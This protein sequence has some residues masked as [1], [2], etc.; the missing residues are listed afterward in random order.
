MKSQINAKDANLHPQD[1]R[2]WRFNR[3]RFQIFQARMSGGGFA[4]SLQRF[5]PPPAR[6]AIYVPAMQQSLGESV[7]VHA[8]N[9][10]VLSEVSHF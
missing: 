7:L 10:S 1:P 4:P 2:K 3:L 8:D 9:I 5:C 6:E